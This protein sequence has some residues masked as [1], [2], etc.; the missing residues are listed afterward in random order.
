MTNPTKTVSTSSLMQENRTFPPSPEVIKRAYINAEQY[1]QMYESSINE[2]DKFWLEQA[3][4]LDWFKKP[5]VSRK[6]VWTPTQKE[7]NTRGLKTD[8]LT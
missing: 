4:T 3:A 5:T 7:S 1:K 8:S 2:P 6:Y